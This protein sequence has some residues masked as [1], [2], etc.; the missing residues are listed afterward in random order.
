MQLDTIL[1][2]IP[3]HVRKYS[4]FQNNPNY[5]DQ[6]RANST[7]TGPNPSTIIAPTTKPGSRRNSQT[8]PTSI[9]TTNDNTNEKAAG[10]NTNPAGISRPPSSESSP[11]LRTPGT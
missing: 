5:R 2:D 11:A 8:S 7:S 4:I 6:L 1:E 10:N 3:V 9:S